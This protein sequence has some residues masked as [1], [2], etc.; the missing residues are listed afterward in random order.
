[1]STFH[2]FSLSD[3]DLNYTDDVRI[4][5]KKIDFSLTSFPLDRIYASHRIV[6]FT[7]TNRKKAQPTLTSS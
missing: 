3:A 5:P 6:S 4:S 1:M 2:I 7:M